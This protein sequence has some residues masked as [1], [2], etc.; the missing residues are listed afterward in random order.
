MFK[1]RPIFGCGFDQYTRE[2]MP[3]LAD[4]TSDLPLEKAKP[5]VQHNAFLGLL[6]ETGFIGAGLF[7]VR[8]ARGK[9]TRVECDATRYWMATGRSGNGAQEQSAYDSEPRDLPGRLLLD[10][11]LHASS[12]PEERGSCATAIFFS[13]F[14]PEH[15]TAS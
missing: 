4:R 1:D 15:A 6:V 7:M 2:K 12:P 14:F 13:P 3:Y 10:S 8:E 5:Y 9:G 11:P